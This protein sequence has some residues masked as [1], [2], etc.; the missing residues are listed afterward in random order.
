VSPADKAELKVLGIDEMAAASTEL[1][2]PGRGHRIKLIDAKGLGSSPSGPP[3]S[4]R[5]LGKGRVYYIAWNLP[6][7]AIRKLLAH[8]CQEAD[9]QPPLAIR[10]DD[11]IPADYVETHLFGEATGGRYVAYG[12]DFG[13]GPRRARLV[14]AAL[15]RG[16]ARYYVRDIRPPS[17]LA[18]GGGAGKAAWSA[19]DLAKGI[20]CAL[21]AQD[22]E[23]FL[24]ERADLPP[25]PLEGLTAEQAEVLCWAWRDSPASSR[26]VLIDS[27]HVEEFRTSKP[28]MPTAVKALEDAG[29]EV[30]SSL[31]RLDEQITTSSSKGVARENLSSYQVLVLSGLGHGTR[32]WQ[33][34]ELKRLMRFVEAGGGLLACLKRDW[35]SE[36]MFYEELKPFGIGDAALAIGKGTGEPT[37]QGG[38]LYDPERCILG[39]PLFVALTPAMAHPITDGVK[40]FQTTGV[41][42]LHVANPAIKTL[43]ASGPQSEVMNLWGQRRPAP[44]APVLVALEHGKGRLVVVGCD[45]WLRPDEQALAD[46]QRLLMNAINW[47]GHAGQTEKR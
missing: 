35:H 5:S 27:F 47:L 13:G 46:N 41:R 12:L 9:V 28:K 16:E 24:L 2:S 6:A 14:P 30:N 36:S 38:N 43:F 33:D 32:I 11:N 17:Y 37:G 10:F 39:E 3:I 26:R 45:T 34:A 20:P 25:L 31:S 18:P 15:A 22:P 1:T 4:V 7:P 40:C 8:V 21:P 23:L 42:P 44:N 19:A 29:W